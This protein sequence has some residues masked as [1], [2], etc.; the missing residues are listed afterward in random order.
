MHDKIDNVHTGFDGLLTYVQ[1]QQP[2]MVIHGHQHT[3]R[4]TIVGRTKVL[5]VYGY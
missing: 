5:G 1:Q 4:E 2:S 3:D